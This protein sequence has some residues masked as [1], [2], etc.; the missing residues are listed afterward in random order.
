MPTTADIEA[1]RAFAGPIVA[2]FVDLEDASGFQRAKGDGFAVTPG[3]H[4]CYAVR[5]IV[6]QVALPADEPHDRAN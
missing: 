2:E 1:G 6:P 3:V 5:R 4:R